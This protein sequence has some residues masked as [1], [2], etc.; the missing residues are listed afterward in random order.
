MNKYNW[1]LPAYELFPK[2][3]FMKLQSE[4]DCEYWEDRLEWWRSKEEDRKATDLEIQ[5]SEK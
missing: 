1:G 4:N 2:L 3:L 5:L